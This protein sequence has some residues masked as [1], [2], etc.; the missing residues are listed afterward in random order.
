M[1]WPCKARR[2]LTLSR[3]GAASVTR[4]GFTF[5][6][7]LLSTVLFL[8]TALIIGQ[9]LAAASSGIC[10]IYAQATLQAQLGAAA[11]SLLR[12]VRVATL[13]QTAP[14]NTFAGSFT[15]GDLVLCLS[16]PSIDAQGQPLAG[17][18]ADT[19]VY[20]LDVAAG[21]LRRTVDAAAG[22]SRTDLQEIVASSLSTP[23]DNQLFPPSTDSTVSFSLAA[24]VTRGGQ[25]YRMDL[26]S[27][28]RLRNS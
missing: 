6:E 3:G 24:Q 20:E 27:R 25:A 28:G 8:L 4:R 17:G 14:C 23:P 2:I 19:V 18:G 5:V 21:V 9:F 26:F 15:P 22:S 12:D 7:L 10:T 13:R 11:R 16:V 1:A